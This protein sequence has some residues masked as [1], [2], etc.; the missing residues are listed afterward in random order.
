MERHEGTRFDG[1]RVRLEHR[2]LVGTDVGVHELGD[3]GF[4]HDV[5]HVT[6]IA[7]D[8]DCIWVLTDDDVIWR[9]DAS[10][11]EEVARLRDGNARVLAAD[12]HDVWIG[13][14]KAT[15]WRLRGADVERVVSFDA[16]PSHAEWYTPWGGPPD[17]FSIDAGRGDVY[18]NVHV[19]GILRSADRGSSWTPTI[20]LHDDV[21][22][23]AV[24]SSGA[25]WAAT[26][27]RGL[28]RST[29]RGATWDYVTRGLTSSY[30]LG[31]APTSD[32]ALV[33]TSSGPGAR[34]GTI[35]RLEG[36]RLVHSADGLP[37]DLGG[38][39]GAGRWSSMGD[40]VVMAA[41]DGT[42][43]AS[44]DGGRSWVR[45]SAVIDAT[46]VALW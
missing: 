11:I 31:V 41:P 10:G 2:V 19:G 30:A 28:A 18:V 27:R 7:P 12:G 9:A 38:T 14:T 43:R 21:H 5:G 20:D 29:D 17:V 46:T 36:G 35:S 16:A 39:V 22:D 25:V 8:S 1:R 26:G 45:A 42:I 37:D 4:A 3:T 24:D 44:N 6:S 34:D 40:E 23:V 15:L 33:C 13:G 32:G